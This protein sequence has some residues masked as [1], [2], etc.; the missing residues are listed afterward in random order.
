MYGIDS[1][2]YW[3]RLQHMSSI[4]EQEC[5]QN[6]R[7]PLAAVLRRVP[8]RDHAKSRRSA[9]QRPDLLTSFEKVSTSSTSSNQQQ[10]AI[11]RAA[12]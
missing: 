3:N 2:E 7:F 6:N 9:E 12:G 11:Q 5:F 8:K 4:R 1:P 10:S